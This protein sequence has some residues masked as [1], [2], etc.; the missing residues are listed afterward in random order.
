MNTDN[1]RYEN[2]SMKYVSEA[3]ELAWKELEREKGIVHLCR[4][5]TGKND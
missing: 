2:F 5:E 1:I 4:K 3:A